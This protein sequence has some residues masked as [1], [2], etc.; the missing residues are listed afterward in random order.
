M[1]AGPNRQEV[2]GWRKLYNDVK[3]VSLCLTK[4]HA[5][6]T[7]WEVE[8]QLHAFLTSALEGGGEWSASRPC[9]FT[10]GERTPGIH[11]MGFWVGP[12][13]GVEEVAKKNMPNS[14]R[15]LNPDYPA[16]NLG[17]S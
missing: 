8:L 10:P 15:E 16:Y 17:A 1:G 5:M 7:Y 9:R 14:F 12:R 2:R 11:W 13:A 3:V 6:K 4:H